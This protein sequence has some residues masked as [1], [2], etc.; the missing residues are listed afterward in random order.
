VIIA[1]T[2]ISTDIWQGSMI[3]RNASDPR[4]CE[5]KTGKDDARKC[6]ER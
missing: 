5:G 3:P 1:V 6:L 4:A 2:Q